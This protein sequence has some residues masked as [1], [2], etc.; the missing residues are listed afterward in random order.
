[1]I[2]SIDY[3]RQLHIKVNDGRTFVG[4]AV[5][6]LIGLKNRPQF[7]GLL[8]HLLYFFSLSLKFFDLF[9]FVLLAGWFPLR[10]RTGQKLLS[11]SLYVKCVAQFDYNEEV[12]CL[13][14]SMIS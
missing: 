6:N 5:I 9:C 2:R 13:N 11:G 7:C 4:R 12:I 14:S 10:D 1:M 8:F 3:Q